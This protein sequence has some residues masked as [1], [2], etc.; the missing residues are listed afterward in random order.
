ME[1]TRTMAVE[2]EYWPTFD[3]TSITG[4]REQR[5]AAYREVREHLKERVATRF[6]KTGQS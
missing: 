4:T 2:V 5:L 3:P 1:F 6:L